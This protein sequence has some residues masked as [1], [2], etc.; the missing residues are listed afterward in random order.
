MDEPRTQV[1]RQ[2]ETEELLKS[3]NGR[4]SP[5]RNGS[6]DQR[7]ERT[8]VS[9]DDALSSPSSEAI[10]PV[11]FLHSKAEHSSDVPVGPGPCDAFP[12][13]KLSPSQQR[14]LIRHKLRLLDARA[15]RSPGNE[16]QKFDWKA[17]LRD[18]SP[19]GWKDRLNMKGSDLQEIQLLTGL[20]SRS[21][22]AFVDSRKSPLSQHVDELIGAIR[23][24]LTCV[25]GDAV[26]NK[27]ASLSGKSP[28]LLSASEPGNTHRASFLSNRGRNTSRQLDFDS[29][30]I[31]FAA[32][33]LKLLD[34][35]SASE[36]F[37]S[38][39]VPEHLPCRRTVAADQVASP[40]PFWH[41]L[42]RCCNLF[43]RSGINRILSKNCWKILWK[44]NS[45][46][47]NA[48]LKS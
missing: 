22:S 25:N 29:D 11:A 14:A 1:F 5:V 37:V 26:S 30:N 12:T 15:H 19:A 41:A 48:M 42:C 18:M 6:H 45:Q 20:Q 10:R 35:H 33:P 16:D 38:A 17:T 34:Q 44:S 7:N 40:L 32:S 27:H 47:Q 3:R 2:I 23:T 43:F 9:T 21:E 4:Q 28:L 8:F 46:C 36:E 31:S 13:P 24:K 39:Q